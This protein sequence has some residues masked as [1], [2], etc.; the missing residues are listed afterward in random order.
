MS[1][2][3]TTDERLVIHPYSLFGTM[4]PFNKDAPVPSKNSASLLS[5]PMYNLKLTR[6]VVP[7]PDRQFSMRRSMATNLTELIDLNM[8][9]NIIVVCS[10]MLCCFYSHSLAMFPDDCLSGQCCGSS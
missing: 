5:N 6:S 7:V 1:I 2:V 10:L 3:P 4:I 9:V 8:K